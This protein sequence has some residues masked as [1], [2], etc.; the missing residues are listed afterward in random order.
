MSFV[1]E[2][3][4]GGVVASC[5]FDCNVYMWDKNVTETEV[6]NSEDKWVKHRY[7]KQVGSLVLGTG[8]AASNEISEYERNKY[9]KIW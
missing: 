2:L 7:M 9:D 4:D 1:R 5:S 8:S 3:G 6:K